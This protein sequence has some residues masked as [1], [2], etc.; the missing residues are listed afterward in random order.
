MNEVSLSN[1]I[2]RMR[3]KSSKIQKVMNSMIKQ[4]QVCLKRL[5]EMQN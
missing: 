1:N 3:T 5:T 2:N 4:S